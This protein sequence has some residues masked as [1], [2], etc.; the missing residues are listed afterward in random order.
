MKSD[1]CTEIMSDL[2]EWFEEPEGITACAKAVTT[3]PVL[4]ST[5]DGTCIGFIALKYHPPAAAEIFVIATKKARHGQGIGRSLLKA[6]EA[7]IRESGYSLLTVKTLAPRGK[8]E[9]H[10]D[11]TREFYA[12]NGFLKAEVFPTLWAETHPCLFLVK[13]L[14]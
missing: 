9:P 11:A 7:H 14:K 8:D 6:A 12:R 3:L 4:A 5:S 10:L 2:P 1:L 13:P